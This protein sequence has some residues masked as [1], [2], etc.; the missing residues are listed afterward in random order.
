MHLAKHLNTYVRLSLC[1]R[2]LLSLG[3]GSCPPIKP[4]YS[5]FSSNKLSHQNC[6][7]KCLPICRVCMRLAASRCSF[8]CC[9]NTLHCQCL[10]LFRLSWNSPSCLINIAQLP[11]LDR[12]SQIKTR[13]FTTGK[14]E[15]TTDTKIIEFLQQKRTTTL[16]FMFVKY[17]LTNDSFTATI[18]QCDRRI[19]FFKWPYGTYFLCSFILQFCQDFFLLEFP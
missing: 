9:G 19:H 3:F 16:V 13:V 17:N 4:N 5:A 8:F 2:L 15:N 12:V 11:P 7:R 14:S 6:A 18:F 10:S 1:L